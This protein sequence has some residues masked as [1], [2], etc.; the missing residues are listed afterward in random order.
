MISHAQVVYEKIHLFPEHLTSALDFF[1]LDAFHLYICM[2]DRFTG[3]IG[4]I[5][6]NYM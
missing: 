2:K 5:P 3:A 4:K 1:K 6:P